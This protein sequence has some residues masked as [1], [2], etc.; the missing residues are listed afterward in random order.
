MM[1][2]AAVIGV[3]SCPMGG[4]EAE[5]VAEVLHVDRSRFEVALLLALGYR[6]QPQPAKHRLPMEELV[7]FR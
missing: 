1:T 5:A 7:T 6:A 3:D 2:A 4:F